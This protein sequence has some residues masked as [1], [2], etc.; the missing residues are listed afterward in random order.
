MT[1]Q[2]ITDEEIA[3]A[4]AAEHIRALAAEQREYAAAAEKVRERERIA[5]EQP[6][7]DAIGRYNAVIQQDLRNPRFL[8]DLQAA[9]D[10][11]MRVGAPLPRPADLPDELAQLAARAGTGHAVSLPSETLMRLAQE[12]RSLRIQRSVRIPLTIRTPIR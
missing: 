6:R 10:E 9:T 11:C 2:P 5:R 8:P 4:A 7:E 1:T 3:V 12:L